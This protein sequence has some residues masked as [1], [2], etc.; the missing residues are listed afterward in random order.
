MTSQPKYDPFS[1]VDNMLKEVRE[2]LTIARD[3]GDI[4]ELVVLQMLLQVTKELHYIDNT[5]DLITKVLDSAIAF[6]DGERAFIMLLEDSAPR[7]KMGRNVNGEYLRHEDFSPSTTV[8]AQV[9]EARQVIIVPDAQAD[10]NLNK[11]QSILSLSLRTIMC[12]PLIAKKEI[13]GLLYVDSRRSSLNTFTNRA[14]LNFL[15][16][17]A[18]QAAVAIRNAQKFET[19]T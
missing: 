3:A 1:D 2:I 4:N 15:S 12:A 6:V 7:F 8:I 17:L 13:I 19:H 10:E 16:S 14:Y 18:D 9:L 5:R 11:R